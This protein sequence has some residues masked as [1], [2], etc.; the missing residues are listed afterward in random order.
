MIP[1]GVTSVKFYV[2]K[3]ASSPGWFIDNAL[4][5]KSTTLALDEFDLNVFRVYP[6]PSQGTFTLKGK[7]S[8]Q[9]FTIFDIHGRL[10]QSAKN[11]NSNEVNIQLNNK[12]KGLYLIKL[13]D[14]D[15]NISSKKIII[16]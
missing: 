10:I 16:N 15:G 12:S 5:I 6:N 8:I 4:L 13:E 2:E 9:S 3:G 14:I 1:A 7:T 11:M